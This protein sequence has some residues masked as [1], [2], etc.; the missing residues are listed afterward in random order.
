MKVTAVVGNG[1]LLN[2]V[3][4]PVKKGVAKLVDTVVTCRA[5]NKRLTREENGAGS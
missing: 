4:G 5:K 1:L 3:R 2:V